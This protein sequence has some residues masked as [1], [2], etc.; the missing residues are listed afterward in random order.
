MPRLPRLHTIYNVKKFD[1]L[2]ALAVN[3]IGVLTT[4][5]FYTYFGKGVRLDEKHHVHDMWLNVSRIRMDEFR[6][7]TSL[8]IKNEN[9]VMRFV[10]CFRSARTE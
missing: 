8:P 7:D 1:E 3:K 2:K 10:S 6:Y 5:L 4:I 9:N